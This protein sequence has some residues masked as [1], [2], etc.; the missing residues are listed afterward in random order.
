MGEER[1]VRSA[2]K[3]LYLPLRDKQCVPCAPVALSLALMD[4]QTVPLALRALTIL[5][6]AEGP[7]V[8]TVL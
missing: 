4:F 6:R 5:P 3:D 1:I 2:L 8:M 7:L